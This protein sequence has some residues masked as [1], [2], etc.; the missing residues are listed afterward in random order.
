MKNHALLLLHLS[1]PYFLIFSLTNRWK[2]FCVII[3]FSLIS[4]IQTEL[5]VIAFKLPL[6]VQHPT[7]LD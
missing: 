3:Y 6:I 4:I 5:V 1:L 2:Y 7:R